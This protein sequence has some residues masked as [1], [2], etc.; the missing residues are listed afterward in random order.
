MN[1]S[2]LP[3]PLVPAEVDLRGYDFMPFYG[4]ALSRSE[5]SKTTNDMAWRFGVMLWWESWAKQ[6]P[7]ASLPDDD[8]ILAQACGL[9]RDV[10]TWRKIKVLALHGFVKC[11][12]GRLYHKFL[13]V[14]AVDAWEGRVKQRMKTVYARIAGLKKRLLLAPS[15]A[16]KTHIQSLI[17]GLEQ[18]LSQ[19]IKK[20]VTD[21]LY[22]S[23]TPLSQGQLL[24]PEV[25]RQGQRQGEG[26]VQGE[27]K[28]KPLKPSSAD[29]EADPWSV[30]KN[31]LISRGSSKNEA[32][33]FIGGMAKEYGKPAVIEAIQAAI[34]AQAA[35]PKDYIVAVLQNRPKPGKFD[36]VASNLEFIR[37]QSQ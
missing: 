9:G 30:G 29:A 36:P 24:T 19:T 6:V 25:Q 7:A 20:P 34:N 1:A 35:V 21:N 10:K 5:F 27:D 14:A 23:D 26:E 16:E 37:R 4:D 12:D 18:S 13:A 33:S 22:A 8:A 28:E 32:G 17:L 11:S 15:D 2:G 31:F 3:A